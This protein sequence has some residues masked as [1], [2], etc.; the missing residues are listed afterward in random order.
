ML[1][2]NN[3]HPPPPVPPLIKGKF[4]LIGENPLDSF[5]RE[6]SITSRRF[7]FLNS[8]NDDMF[9]IFND[10]Y[11]IERSNGYMYIGSIFSPLGGQVGTNIK[12]Y[13]TA[14]YVFI[15]FIYYIFSFFGIS[16]RSY[17]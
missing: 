11:N 7:F 15:I 14:F 5:S 16:T 4:N 2:C 6:L 13:S 12:F 9:S 17:I 10:K 8:C 1:K 3:F